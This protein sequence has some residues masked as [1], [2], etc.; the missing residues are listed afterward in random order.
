MRWVPGRR[1]R[2]GSRMGSGGSPLP[3]VVAPV[4]LDDTDL[5]MAVF[6][7]ANGPVDIDN[8]RL[9]SPGVEALRAAGVR[10]VVPLVAQ[11]ELI[12]LLCLGERLSEQPYTADDRDLLARLAAQAA[13]ALRVAQLVREQQ[14]EAREHERVEAELRIAQLIQRNFLP[15]DVRAPDGWS[16]ETFYRPARE[17]G[18]DFFDVV[19]LPDGR[20]GVIV[21]DV[22]DKGVP[23]ALVMASTRSILRIAAQQV[24]EPGAVLEHVNDQLVPDIP[25]A[26]FV[27]CLYG[28]LDPGSGVLRFANAGHNLPCVVHEGEV[29][30]PRATG[31]PLGLLPSSRYEETAVT[32]PPGGAALLYSDALPEAHGPHGDMF[33]FPAVRDAVASFTTG[34]LVD[35]LLAAVGQFVAD[36]WE[37]E[38]DLTFVVLRRGVT[39]RLEAATEPAVAPAG[40]DPNVLLD[41]TCPSQPAGEREIA[42][43]VAQAAVDAGLDQERR[44]ALETAVAEAVMNAMEHGNAYREDLPVRVQLAR[45]DDTI[46]VTVRDAGLGGAIPTT[47]GVPDLAAKLRGEESP[48]GWGLFLVTG[49]VDGLRTG[50]DSD[51]NVVE[52]LMQLGG[53]DG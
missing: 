12:G 53:T 25:E 43:E 8:L 6:A 16:I 23:A 1:R 34:A 11:G 26:M 18:G 20:L 46:R 52:L 24:I 5:V 37:Q 22:T 38:D 28:V 50:R 13:P 19:P 17:V 42:L 4:H 27:T 29:A 44:R 32:I 35:H 40:T 7:S 3:H 48:R 10:L 30:E 51:G 39:A 47:N 15:H 49:M 33:G 41:I 2:P 9:D 31:M 14:Q 45:T 21:G 36:D